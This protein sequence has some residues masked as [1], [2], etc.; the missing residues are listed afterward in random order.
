MGPLRGL[1][2]WHTANSVAEIS[3]SLI[4]KQPPGSASVTGQALRRFVSDLG[5]VPLLG[6]PGTASF[7][8]LSRLPHPVR[9]LGATLPDTGRIP[10]PVRATG[11]GTCV[12]R[13][14]SGS[15]AGSAANHAKF[16]HATASAAAGSV[17]GSVV[18]YPSLPHPLGRR[19]RPAVA[20]GGVSVLR[21]LSRRLAGRLTKRWLPYSGRQVIYQPRPRT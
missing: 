4:L 13:P 16:R 12:F 7:P 3:T 15:A 5:R 21:R 14:G 9:A 17:D 10:H 6:A 1:R 20:H 8:D 19:G 11:P 2:V 18:R